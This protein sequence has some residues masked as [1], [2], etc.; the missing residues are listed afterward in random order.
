MAL[1]Q[2]ASGDS[3]PGDACLRGRDL[4]EVRSNWVP[5]P[6]R[7]SP[8][9][10]MQPASVQLAKCEPTAPCIHAGAHTVTLRCCD[11]QKEAERSQGAGRLPY[12]EATVRERGSSGSW[13][14]E[15][16][17]AGGPRHVA[18]PRGRSRTACPWLLL[19]SQLVA[20]QAPG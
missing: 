7:G 20:L 5:S 2:V 6:T 16:G 1:R 19:A 14:V 4:P 18:C 10:V 13:G 3:T 9:P 8:H 15:D 12:P 17:Q 11:P